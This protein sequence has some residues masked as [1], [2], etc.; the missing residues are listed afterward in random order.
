MNTNREKALSN[1][2]EALMKSMNMYIWPIGI[3]KSISQY[4]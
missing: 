1:K 3:L 4:I 2:T